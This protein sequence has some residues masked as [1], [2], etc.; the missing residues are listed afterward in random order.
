M[1]EQF[2]LDLLL[3]LLWCDVL[4]PVYCVDHFQ[5]ASLYQPCHYLYHVP[6]RQSA[7]M[8]DSVFLYTKFI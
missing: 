6:L 5:Q 8:S 4:L 2:F 1:N 3:E 7:N